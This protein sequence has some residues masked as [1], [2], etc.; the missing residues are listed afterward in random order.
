MSDWK[1]LTILHG[2]VEGARAAFEQACESIIR[3]KFSTRPVRGVRAHGGDGGIDIYVGEL[4]VAPVDVYQCKYFINGVDDS[5]KSQ[6]RE[7]FKTVENSTD[8][9][10]NAWYLCLPVNL[11]VSEATWFDGWAG[12][13]KTSVALIPA[14]DLLSWSEELGLADTIFQRRDS[15]KLDALLA[16]LDRVNQDPW[17]A[18]VDQTETDCY[19]ILLGLL[20][21]HLRC[22][23]GEYPHLESLG[24]GAEAGDRLDTCQYFKSVFA[25]NLKRSEKIWVF[26][27]LNDFTC[28]PMAYK[29]IRRY[30]ELVKKSKEL[31]RDRSLST[32]EFYST[33]SMF[34]SPV[35]KDLRDEAHWTVEF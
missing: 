9:T 29:F 1:D 17:N 25:G 11:S 15:L 16:R 19:R 2:N 10:I 31:G 23:Q 14:G 35:L 5:Q 30:D 27:L 8:F 33:W 21:A 20:R 4:G 6:I 12:N 24:N 32:S 26:N 28:E 7:S 3:A 18:L 22:L 13:Q 34:R